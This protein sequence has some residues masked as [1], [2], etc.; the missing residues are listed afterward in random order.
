MSN[1]TIKIN[2]L[3]FNNQNKTKKKDKIKKQVNKSN[4]SVNTNKIKSSFI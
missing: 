1:K 3:F 2:P 4:I